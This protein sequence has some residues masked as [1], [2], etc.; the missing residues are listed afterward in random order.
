MAWYQKLLYG[1]DLDEEQARENQLDQALA[2]QNKKDLAKGVY[3]QTA[4][5]AAEAHRQASYID[6]VAG[7]VNTAFVEGL[8]DGVSNVRSAVGDA[9]TFPLRLISWKIW[10]LAGVAVFFYMGGGLWLRGV[11][12]RR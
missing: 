1:V 4:Y 2:E 3:D 8:G 11:L 7:Q 9:V 5:D 12:N 6:D 10:L